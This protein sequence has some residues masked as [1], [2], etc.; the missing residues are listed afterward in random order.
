MT[1]K[2]RWRKRAHARARADQNGRFAAILLVDRVQ[3]LLAQHLL[4]QHLAPAVKVNA[5]A[6]PTA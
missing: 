4:A 5:Q 6:R 2:R 1:P 3:H